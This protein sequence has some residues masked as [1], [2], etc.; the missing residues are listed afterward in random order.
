[1]LG[2]ISE[3]RNELARALAL[4]LD[5]AVLTPLNENQYSHLLADSESANLQLMK[6]I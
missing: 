2:E 6:D 4:K 5:F 3:R 1:M